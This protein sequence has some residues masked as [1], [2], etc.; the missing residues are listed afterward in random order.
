MELARASITDPLTGLP[1]RAALD[2]RLGAL[3]HAAL[4][5]PV[6]VSVVMVDL[7]HFKAVNDRFGHAVGDAVLARIGGLLIQGTRA[8]DLVA[9]YGGE[10]FVVLLDRIGGGRAEAFAER[11]RVA[12]ADH[13]WRQLHADLAVTVSL[14]VAGDGAGRAPRAVVRAADEALYR[15]KA[16]GRNRVVGAGSVEV[17]APQQ[18]QSV[19]HHVEHGVEALDRTAR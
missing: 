4:E 2:Q 5:R 18:G 7:D 11:L 15:A 16:Q 14:G 1:N 8:G 3:T 12:V 10:E 17:L 13:P 19:G 6:T 9:R